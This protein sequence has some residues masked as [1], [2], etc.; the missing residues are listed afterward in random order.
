MFDPTSRYFKLSTAALTITAHDGTTRQ[1]AYVRRRFIP[2]PQGMTTLLEHTVTE[3]DRLDNITARYLGDPAKF[4]QL[5]DA[6]S[7]LRP[8]DLTD[9]GAE[10]GRATPGRVGHTIR[11]ALSL[12]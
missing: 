2:S 1:L 11:V 9:E 6:N 5:C 10:P 8:S 12:A 7:A 3:G 4:W